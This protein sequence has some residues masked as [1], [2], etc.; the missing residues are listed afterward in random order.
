MTNEQFGNLIVK[1]GK[2]LKSLKGIELYIPEYYGKDIT[3][4]YKDAQMI[5]DFLKKLGFKGD[6]NINNIIFPSQR[7]I[8]RILE[9]LIENVTNHDSNTL[10]LNE[11][12]S[13][14]NFLKLKVSQ[15]LSA[16]SKEPWILPEIEQELKEQS[17]NGMK[18]II[19]YDNSKIQNFKKKIKEITLDSDCNF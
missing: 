12:F 16:W 9:F 2:K 17:I 3:S 19:K 1:I 18:K 5:V 4:K 7:D 15:K 11:N 14:K 13:E 6:I 8:Q 10:E